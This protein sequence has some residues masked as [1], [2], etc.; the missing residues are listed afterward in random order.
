MIG[1]LVN[2]Y[3]V[4]DRLKNYRKVLLLNAYPQM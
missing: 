4:L 2:N 1:K 3:T